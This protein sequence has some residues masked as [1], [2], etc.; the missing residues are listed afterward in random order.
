MKRDLLLL[1]KKYKVSLPSLNKEVLIDEELYDEI[2]DFLPRSVTV[3]FAFPGFIFRYKTGTAL[4][5][6]ER[7]VEALKEEYGVRSILWEPPSFELYGDGIFLEPDYRFARETLVYSLINQPSSLVSVT[8]E[9][10]LLSIIAEPGWPEYSP[11]TVLATLFYDVVD[12]FRVESQSFYPPGKSSMGIAF[13]HLKKPYPRIE[14]F[15]N[16]L[17]RLFLNRKK[18]VRVGS[19]KEEKRVDQM[20]PEE[21]LELFETTNRR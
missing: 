20:E 5:T 21:L 3:P 16:F 7:K 10:V 13:L 1:I 9:S 19:Q 17:K 2:S 12:A 15:Y 6:D 11:I 8:R 14:E 18:K 4:D